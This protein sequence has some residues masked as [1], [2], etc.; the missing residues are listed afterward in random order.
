M[1]LSRRLRLCVLPWLA[2][3][4]AGCGASVLP[5]V[6]SESERLPLAR[7]FYDRGDYRDAIEMLKT[8][9]SS[10]GG[11]AQVDE[12]IYL[13]GD[14]YLKI[15]EWTSASG[16]FERLLRDY[17]E[18]DSSGAAAFK[19]GDAYYGQTRPADFDQEYTRKA[20]DQWTSYLREY[21]G[22]WLNG[23]AAQRVEKARNRLGSK[24]TKTGELYLKLQQPGPARVYFT[25]VTEQ[26][27]DTVAR[28]IGR[29]HV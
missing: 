17:P 1:R 15:K 27:A 23:Q 4:L 9:I 18:S 12:A 26:Y 29:A 3:A 14:S 11:S 6:H 24:L 8:F 2:L 19:L 25:Q 20:L 28:Q 5:S 10:S 7:R 22:H 16:E 21:P 13:L